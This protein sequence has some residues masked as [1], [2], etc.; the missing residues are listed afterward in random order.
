MRAAPK[1]FTNYLETINILASLKQVWPT[2]RHSSQVLQ[3]AGVSLM[4]TE[5][6]QVKVEMHI[7][8]MFHV[9]CHDQMT[10]YLATLTRG[11]IVCL[12]L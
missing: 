5:S 3:E 6:P 10:N 1:I 4:D 8:H 2:D 7:T 9:R 12:H 11:M